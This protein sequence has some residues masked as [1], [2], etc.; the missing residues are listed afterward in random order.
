MRK[1]FKIDPEILLAIEFFA[2]IIF[3]VGLYIY[4]GEL[5]QE[6]WDVCIEECAKLY[7]ECSEFRILPGWSG[8]IEYK[9]GYSYKPI[10]QSPDDISELWINL[11]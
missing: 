8:D 9:C 3:G 2:L 4:S 5:K 6:A 11:T 10:D 7:M 1:K